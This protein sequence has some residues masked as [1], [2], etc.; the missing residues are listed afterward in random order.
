MYPALTL[1][2]V[3]YLDGF[4]KRGNVLQNVTDIVVCLVAGQPLQ[5]LQ[6]VPVAT[7]VPS[8][9]WVKIQGPRFK[10]Q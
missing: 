8:S 7:F 9:T 10:A 6:S 4:F 3:L 1:D 2:V 5:R